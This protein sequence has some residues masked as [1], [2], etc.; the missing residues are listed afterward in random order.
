MYEQLVQASDQTPKYQTIADA[1]EE[2][3]G[4]GK[5][6][7]G[8]RLPTVRDLSQTLGVS[9]TTIAAAY[10]LLGQRNYISG[11]VGRGTFVK[12]GRGADD[13]SSSRVPTTET[14]EAGT[15]WRRR[16]L[17]AI[18]S[19]L[20]TAFPSALDCIS[21]Q[22][23]TALLPTDV[24]TYG[25]RAALDQVSEDNLQYSG[26]VLLPALAHQIRPRL[27][28]DGILTNESDIVVGSSAQQWI[29]LAVQIAARLV[30]QKQPLVAVE[31]PGYA[32]IFDALE[33][34]GCRLIGMEVDQNGVLPSSLAQALSQGVAA[35]L[36]TPRALNPT[37]VS[38]TSERVAEIAAVLTSYPGSIVIEDDHFA[39]LAASNPGSLL[40][41]TAV[42]D[43][44]IYVRSFSKSIAPDLRLAIAVARSPLRVLLGEA[45]AFA[46]GWSSHLSQLALAHILAQPE[47]DVL[48]AGAQQ[49]Y[50]ERRAAA[51]GA[52]SIVKD[53]ATVTPSVDGVNLWVR[54]A[55]G[56]D[57][58]EVI[59][60]AA[61]LG[62]LAAPG[63]PFYVRV[64][65]NDAVRL[66]AGAI[67]VHGAVKAGEYLAK[68]IARAAVVAPSEVVV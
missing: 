18:A 13:V 58:A 64:G 20:R 48:L 12:G 5:L 65:H 9:A 62:V 10:Q 38:W 33:Y 24:I 68:A 16:T 25:W 60:Q 43:R 35:V 52:L 63:E 8:E 23:D 42:E 41:Y 7:S 50:A 55:P 36:L 61:A 14:W 45:K 39:G 66:N 26:P 29:V 49:A 28:A 6:R 3:I 67:N 30:G 2:A 57:A 47:L 17:A 22:P 40:G 1:I 34:Q 56:I 46:D 59:E 32:T 53:L 27:E 31:E 54:L 51:A 4:Q 19:R 15:P 21:G 44:V 37:G 11:V